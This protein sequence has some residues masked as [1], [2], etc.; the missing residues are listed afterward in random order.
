M[1]RREANPRV[2]GRSPRTQS[3][4]R[5]DERGGVPFGPPDIPRSR[6]QPQAAVTPAA[7]IRKTLITS[8][9]SESF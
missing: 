2:L 7:S 9:L 4:V 3:E 6:R 5:A 1:P 8:R